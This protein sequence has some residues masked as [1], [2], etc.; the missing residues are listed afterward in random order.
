MCICTS[1]YAYNTPHTQTHMHTSTHKVLW[2]KAAQNC[3]IDFSWLSESRICLFCI[4]AEFYRTVPYYQQIVRSSYSGILDSSHSP[5]LPVA[6]TNSFLITLPPSPTPS[7][8]ASVSSPAFVDLLLQLTR[9]FPSVIWM[10]RSLWPWPFPYPHSECHFK[11]QLCFY[12]SIHMSLTLKFT[13]HFIP[14]SVHFCP[15]FRCLMVSTPPVVGRLRAGSVAPLQ[16][17]LPSSVHE[18]S[19]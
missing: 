18:A 10:C 4:H 13:E 11:A 12:S 15:V 5:H 14:A 2:W 8:S 3:T 6:P 19:R 9:L 16:P 17:L 1:T 7:N